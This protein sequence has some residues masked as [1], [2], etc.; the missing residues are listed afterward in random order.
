MKKALLIG[1]KDLKVA[2]RDRAALVLMLAAPFVLTL[3]LGLVTGSLDGPS[4]QSGLQDIPVIIIDQDL[5]LIHI[6]EPTRPY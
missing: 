3:G 2:A 5:S 6:S 4:S 1:L